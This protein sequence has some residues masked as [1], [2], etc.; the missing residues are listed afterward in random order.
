M[1]GV[2]PQALPDARLWV[3][4]DARPLPTMSDV[5]LPDHASAAQPARP[6]SP[7]VTQLYRVSKRARAFLEAWILETPI[8][9]RERPPVRLRP[10]AI[11]G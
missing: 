10:L 7:P 2:R 6:I 11:R 5:L 8:S 1:C 3:L 9:I 4:H